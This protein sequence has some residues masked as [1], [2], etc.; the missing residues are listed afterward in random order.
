[1]AYF[2]NSDVNLVNLHFGIRAV[3][4]YGAGAF[5]FVFMLKSGVALPLVLVSLAC[6][7]AGRFIIRPSVV[8]LAA[9]YGLR[10]VLVFGTLLNAVEAPLLGEVQGVGSALVAFCIVSSVADT[11]YWTTYHA[12][13]AA[14]GDHEHR[15][16]QLGVREAVVAIVGIISP[17]VMGFALVAFGPR[18]AFGTTAFIQLFSVI[19]LLFTPRVP[20]VRI[21]PGAFKA[22]IPGMLLF[23]ADGWIQMG[24]G[25]AW[26]MALFLS[27][28]EDFTAYGGA[29][30]IAALVG[31][32]ASLALGRHID[33]GHGKRAVWLAFI[34][35]GA[36]IVFRGA[37]VGH[38]T[39]SVIANALGALVAALYTP[40]LMTAVYN[41]AK[42]SPCPL[43]FHVA[44]EGGWD[45]GG[46]SACLI[47]A[48]LIYLGAPL[49]VGVLLSLAGA[50]GSFVMLRRYYARTSLAT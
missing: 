16:H 18:I 14:V 10:N 25:I 33:A 7:L 27:L 41:L 4:I 5:F 12:Y 22:A 15:G 9:R 32:V 23:F 48:L 50:V 31:V 11:Y 20:V 8:F 43:R 37:A 3:S 39:L 47:T 38:A 1:M 24:Y 45:A 13:F 6:I 40:T 26:Q 21:A 49:A 34:V 28:G 42:G 29:L 2:R 30:A 35:L 36:T 44:T 19:P 17:L 46:A